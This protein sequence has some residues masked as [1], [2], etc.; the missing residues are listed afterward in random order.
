MYS[1]VVRVL[2]MERFLGFE[3]AV[4]ICFIVVPRITRPV[5]FECEFGKEKIKEQRVSPFQV[6]AVLL[7]KY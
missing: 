3:A 7:R 1:V 2:V 4:I 6:R 5:A